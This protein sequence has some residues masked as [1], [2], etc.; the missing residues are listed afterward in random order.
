MSLP[1]AAPHNSD[2]RSRQLAV[3]GLAL[4]SLFWA[5]NAIIARLSVGDI[6]PISLSFWRWFLPCL[7]LSPFI[8]RAWKRHWH[9]IQHNFIRILALAVLSISTYN[10]VLYLAAQ[11]TSSINITLVSSGLP[12]GTLLFAYFLLGDRPDAR[13]VAGGIISLLGVMTILSN[14]SFNRLMQVEFNKGDMLMLIA[15]SCWSIYSVLLKKWPL[16]IP[17]FDLFCIF[18][19]LGVPFIAPFYLW[20]LTSAGLFELSTENLAMLGYIAVFPSVFAYILWNNG[21]KHIGPGKASIFSYLIP[22]FTS[23]LAITFLQEQLFSYHLI[24]G[25]LAFAGLYLSSANA[26][27]KRTS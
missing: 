3:I 22:V 11:H 1:S 17:G 24:G 14:G 19:S 9:T 18:I 15:V 23:I 2:I 16:N 27:S 7:Y 25:A 12:V 6:S 21:V 26:A 4:T 5:G 20:D 13:Q 10:S 8:Y